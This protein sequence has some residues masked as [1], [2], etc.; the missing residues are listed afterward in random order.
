MRRD[1]PSPLDEVAVGAGG[2]RADDL[3]RACP[4]TCDRSIATLSPVTAT[5]PAARRGADPFR[6]LDR[7]R[8][9]RQPNVTPEVTRR[10]CLWRAGRRLTCIRGDRPRCG[11]TLS[12]SA[13][14]AELLRASRQARPS[15]TGRCLR[16]GPA[17]G[18]SRRDWLGQEQLSSRP[19]RPRRSSPSAQEVYRTAA[20]LSE[21]LRLCYRSLHETGNGLIADGRL[22]DVLRRMAVLRAHAGAP[23]HPAGRAPPHRGDR[24]RSRRH[25]GRRAYAD[26]SEEERDRV[27]RGGVA[28]AR[29]VRARQPAVTT[30]ARPTCSTLPGDRVD[31]AGVAGRV[32]DHHGARGRRTSSPSSSCSAGR[33]SIRPLRVVPLFETAR[34]LRGRR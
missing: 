27:P 32:R 33:A 34:D 14:S 25:G 29:G 11:A 30:R 3:G 7:R 23:R 20:D 15:R 22:A 5:R 12:M 17:R 6:L 4:S 10:A 26:W 31:P 1:R 2:V 24:R 16:D 13:A 21:P 28:R 9:R 18:S 8:S 19:E